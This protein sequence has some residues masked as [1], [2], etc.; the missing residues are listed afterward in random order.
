MLKY[1][2]QKRQTKNP[3]VKWGLMFFDLCY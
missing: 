3:I 1:F 2:R